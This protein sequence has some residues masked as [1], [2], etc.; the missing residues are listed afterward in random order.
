MAVGEFCFSFFFIIVEL[1]S[2]LLSNDKFGVSGSPEGE[3]IVTSVE[4][5]D[6]SFSD[7]GFCPGQGGI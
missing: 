4:D 2:F 1:I 3:V 6:T 7:M 5:F